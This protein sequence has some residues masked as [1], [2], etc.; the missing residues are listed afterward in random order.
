MLVDY[1]D[2][3]KLKE[4]IDFPLLLDV[5]HLK[6]ACNSLNLDFEAELGLMM[7]LSDYIHVS[8]NDGTY[9]AN[10]ALCRESDLYSRLKAYNLEN[11]IITLEIKTPITEILNSFKLLSSLMNTRPD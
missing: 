7:E 11:K 3:V 4:L 2:Y 9:D 10:R 6:V 8:D 5:G 1:D